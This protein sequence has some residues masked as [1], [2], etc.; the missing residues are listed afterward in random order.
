MIEII[1][2]EPCHLDAFEINC[3]SQAAIDN[4]KKISGYLKQSGP[5]FTGVYKGKIIGCAGL[6]ELW[7][8]V[9]QAWA[10]VEKGFPMFKVHK[11]VKQALTTLIESCKYHRVQANTPDDFEM[12]K[13]WLSG[14]GKSK[15]LGFD[16]EVT[17]RKFGP[18]KSDFIQ[19]V[20]LG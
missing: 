13:K 19:Y 11:V 9:A 3:T 16:V 14:N 8:G 5:C 17:L 4:L 15:G 20:R 1:P 10:A 18:D 6:S 7:P 12:G 2:F